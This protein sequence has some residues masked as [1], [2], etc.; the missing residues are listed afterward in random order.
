MSRAKEGGHSCASAALGTRPRRRT[1]LPVRE[2]GSNR[3]GGGDSRRATH[4]HRV[5]HHQRH[6][7]QHHSKLSRLTLFYHPGKASAG[8][9][10]H[11]VVNQAH[12]AP[13]MRMS[14]ADLGLHVEPWSIA[15]KEKHAGH[16]RGRRGKHTRYD[17]VEGW[18][19]LEGRGAWNTDGGRRACCTG[20]F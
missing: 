18:T 5:L 6:Y 11:G 8:H 12:C 14:Q 16:V 17:A 4:Q 9:L 1:N 3:G 2:I 7:R 13:C 15:A 20:A 10:Q 19:P